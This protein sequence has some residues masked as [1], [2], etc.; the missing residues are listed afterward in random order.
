VIAKSFPYEDRTTISPEWVRRDSF[1]P[2]TGIDRGI[3]GIEALPPNGSTSFRTWYPFDPILSGTTVT[4]YPGT[5]NNVLPTNYL[6]GVSVGSG[7]T[8]YLTLNVTTNN[9]KVTTCS[10]TADASQPG[11][12]TATLGVPPTTF[13]VLLAVFDGSSTVTKVWENKNIQAQSVV[14]YRADKAIP[15]VGSSPY[16][17]FYSWLIS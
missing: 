10:I 3:E 8:K 9:G 13:K 1:D 5:V 14:V 12:Q 16:D 15:V 17:E 11:D 2:K 6:T 4:F 7:S